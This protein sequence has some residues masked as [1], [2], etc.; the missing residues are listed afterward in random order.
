[1]GKN[2]GEG[3]GGGEVGGFSLKYGKLVDWWFYMDICSLDT[4]KS[5]PIYDVNKRT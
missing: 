1:M 4:A 2:L 3:V 5:T